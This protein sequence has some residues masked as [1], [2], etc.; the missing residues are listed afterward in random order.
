MIISSL[1][2]LAISSYFIQQRLR[3]IAVRKIFGSTHL[4]VLILII[5][6]FMQLAI[7]AFFIATPIVWYLMDMWLSDFSHRIDLSIWIFLVAG[8]FNLVIAFLTVY[9]QTNKAAKANPVKSLMR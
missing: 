4:E 5:W 1:G 8:L 2:L 9:W 7:I 3:E 6:R